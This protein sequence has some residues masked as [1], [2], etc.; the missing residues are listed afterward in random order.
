CHYF[1]QHRSTIIAAA[2]MSQRFTSSYNDHYSQLNVWRERGVRHYAAGRIL[3]DDALCPRAVLKRTEF[4]NDYLRP[5]RGTQCLAG[6]LKCEDGRAFT[7]TALRG[8]PERD[9]N[10][11]EVRACGVLLPHVTQAFQVHERLQSLHA[12]ELILERQQLAIFLLSSD[13]RIRH[14]NPSA[15]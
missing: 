7:M 10:V 5:N 14:A 11:D 3:L 13:G 1:H 2:G 15:E 4:Y 12:V 6:V 8:E 9:W